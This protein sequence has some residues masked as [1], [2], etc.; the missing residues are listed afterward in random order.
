MN[1]KSLELTGFKSF[2]EAKIQFP[3]GVTAVVGPNG[4]G[5]SNVVDAIL[6]VLGEQ[7]TK[8]LRSERMED[9]IFN[10]TESRKPLGMTEV[11]LILD[12]VDQAKLSG[13][14]GLPTALDQYQE[15]MITRRLYRNGDSEYLINKTPCRLKD[16]RGILLDTRAGIKGHT[17]IEQGRIDQ[18][19]NASPRDR[20]EL[21]EETAGIVRYK[22]QKA[23]ALRK[24]EATSQNL[25]RVRDIVTEVRRQLNSLERQ[26]RQARS[27]QRIQEE[28]KVLE[29]RL[30]LR[31]ARGLC[32]KQ[33]QVDAEVVDLENRES[34]Q[35]AE[36][37]RL[38]GQL[39][40]IRLKLRAGEQLLSST[41]EELM[42]AEQ[43]QTQALTATEVERNRLELYRKQQ[44]QISEDIMRLNLDRKKVA[45]TI[46]SLREGI[47][48][49]EVEVNGAELRLSELER[50]AQSLTERR[51]SV[52]AQEQ[53]ARRE[54][55]DS[56]V[57]VT[58]QEN[59]LRQLQARRAMLLDRIQRLGADETELESQI[60]DVARQHETAVQARVDS[61]ESLRTLQRGREGKAQEAQQCEAHVREAAEEVGRRQEELAVVDSRLGALESVI[62]HEMGFGRTGEED[63]TS[64]RAC[65]G[66]HDSIAEWLVVPPGLERAI[67][68]V[69]GERGRAWLVENPSRGREAIEYLKQKELGRGSF[70]PLQPRWSGRAS[71]EQGSPWTAG[72]SGVVGWAVDLVSTQRE[73]RDVL[74]CLFEGVLIVES[75]EVAIRLWQGEEGSGPKGATFVTL[76]GEMLD[77]AGVMTGGEVESS[78]GLLLRRQ[79]VQRLKTHRLN[80]EQVV[81]EARQR[82]N[83][84]DHES[85][86]SRAA[87]QSLDDEIRARELELLTLGRDE[88]AFTH[89]LGELR[90]R[91]DVAKIERQQAED[92]RVRLDGELQNG[93]GQLADLKQAKSIVEAGLEELSGT[94]GAIEQKSLALQAQLT[95]ARLA[96]AGLRAKREHD[97]AD[98]VRLLKEEGEQGLRVTSLEE[99]AQG[100]VSACQHCETERERHETL[101][102][103]A[104]QRA[105]SIRGAYVAAQEDQA[106]HQELSRELEDSVDDVRRK[107]VACR[108]ARLSVEVRR[109]E[110]NAHLSTLEQTLAGTYQLSLTQALEQQPQERAADPDS[111]NGQPEEDRT[112]G[113][114]E[115]LQTLR[116]KLGRMGPIN[117]AAIEEHQ[118][119]EER[120]RFLTTQEEDLSSSIKSLKEIIQRINRTTKQMFLDTFN[121]LQQ[122]FGEVFCR[123]FPGGRAELILT[124]VVPDHAEGAQ[125]SGESD[126]EP[127][128]DIVA[129][130]PG[131]RLKTITMLS[132]GEKT[133]TAMAL[134][135]A[136]FLIRPTPFCILDEIDAP[137][138]EENIGRFAGVLRE[139]SVSAQFIVITHNKSTMS[140]ADSLFGVTMEEPG[141]SKLLSIRLADLQPA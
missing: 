122:Q 95:E 78:G 52:M 135:F 19:L 103:E 87:L 104:G 81:Q 45:E 79:E 101:A 60:G 66:I 12:N 14:Q 68:A 40:E 124:E 92:E 57:R 31:E 9:V 39:E 130:P 38:T 16:I 33:T 113:L 109:A 125:P 93:D 23:E 61:E 65:E 88:E 105:D 132:G 25:L 4:T 98:L 37:A 106:G 110:V 119:L 24:V 70:I 18:I 41:R 22:K 83:Q 134:I 102:R 42:Q 46:A 127:G 13:V 94:L 100:L 90:Q 77:A 69:L 10:G 2:A 62:R 97:G 29:I 55:L 63:S 30:L 17:V 120:Y 47:S 139:L 43:R 8:T 54:I 133:L 115:E 117:L 89:R 67:E 36:Q 7:S 3:I 131:K 116:A 26:A 73:S 49:T 11:S 85:E 5:K 56:T 140:V 15:I 96:L 123:F 50:G 80:L 111:N 72:G 82:R 48:K 32:A 74:A 91:V 126:D 59:H 121:E 44:E 71:E 27:Y 20:R 136:S 64:L 137:L 129:Q 118:A 138:D 34:A 35:T 1:L 108:E 76:A 51:N 6:W 28:V 53:E 58:N 75:L 84:H 107:L 21:I 128:V 141:V 114:Q 112:K 86:T 99:Q